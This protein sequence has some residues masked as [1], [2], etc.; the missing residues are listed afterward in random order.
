MG[1]FF[2]LPLKALE[3]P[4]Q[5]ASFH[6]RI[7]LTPVGQEKKCLS[8]IDS[9]TGERLMEVVYISQSILQYL[10]SDES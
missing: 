9:N 5:T 1:I 7:S 6:Q 4:Y 10:V 8:F 3:S 2:L